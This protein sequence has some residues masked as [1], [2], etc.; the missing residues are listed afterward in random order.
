MITREAE[1]IYY[2]RRLPERVRKGRG[3]R[4][5]MRN[6]RIYGPPNGYFGEHLETPGTYLVTLGSVF[7][8]IPLRGTVA[9]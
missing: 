3:S 8:T 9:H 7:G 6:I 4:V 5:V 1:G 2:A